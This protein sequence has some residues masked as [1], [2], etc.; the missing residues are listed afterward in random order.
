MNGQRWMRRY[1]DVKKC[2]Q[3][4]KVIQ[5]ESKKE[6]EESVMGVTGVER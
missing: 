6:G 4:E 1:A 5:N 3:E 2:N